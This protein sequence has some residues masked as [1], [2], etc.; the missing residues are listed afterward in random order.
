[1]NIAGGCWVGHA[2][3]HPKYPRDRRRQEHS[4]YGDI[5]AA[6]ALGALEDENRSKLRARKATKDN[7]ARKEAERLFHDHNTSLALATAT[8]MLAD[9]V[10]RVSRFC[11]GRGKEG[12]GERS[13]G[14]ND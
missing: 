2:A 14:A 13:V 1:M 11:G 6:G 7:R 10:G 5:P 12:E 4:K 9:I 8:Y 3:R